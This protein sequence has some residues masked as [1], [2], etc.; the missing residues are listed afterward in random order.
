[1]S[2][3]KVIQEEDDTD[4]V[5]RER[6]GGTNRADGEEKLHC[7]SYRKVNRRCLSIWQGEIPLI[8]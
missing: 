6:D 4:F 7:T 1:M 8:R 2:A 3:W 5:F